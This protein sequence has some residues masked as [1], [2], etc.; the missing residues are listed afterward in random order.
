MTFTQRS[1][2]ERAEWTKRIE[3]WRISGLSIAAWC[4]QHEVTY[5]SFLYWKKRLDPSVKHEQ[6][7]TFVQ[8]TDESTDTGVTVSM[9]SCS[10]RLSQEFDSATL[11]RC[12]D[13]LRGL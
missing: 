4:R 3:N 6:A 2:T 12:V 10:I 5:F 8:L 9:G 7:A 13:V 11:A 1:P